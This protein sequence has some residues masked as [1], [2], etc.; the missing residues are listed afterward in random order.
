M[1]NIPK[2][3]FEYSNEISMSEMIHRHRKRDT[4]LMFKRDYDDTQLNE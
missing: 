2:K 1:K 3:R 4:N